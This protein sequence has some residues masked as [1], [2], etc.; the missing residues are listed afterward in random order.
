MYQHRQ[1]G[2][3]LVELMIA[4]SISLVIILGVTQVFV[5]SKRTY[6]LQNG[7]GSLQENGRFALDSLSHSIG[8]AGYTPSL[9]ALSAFNTA[10]SLDNTTANEDLSFSVDA[11]TASDTIEVNYTSATDCLGNA[12]TGVANDLF[13]LDGTNLM[14]LGSGNGTPGLMAEGVEN[15][16][17]L[18]GED[19]DADKVANRYVSVAN[20]VDWDS[21]VSVRVALLLETSD[22]VAQADA[23]KTYSLLNAP[24][25]G[26]FS[27][28]LLRREFTRTIF[29]RN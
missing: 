23:D 16:Q 9:T 26:P 14:C 21:V 5:A 15:M 13:F 17:I 19:T 1:Q 28:T 6:N 12:T 2:L 4:M 18:Y 3:S 29:L 24:P 10:T 7:I 8:L 22:G 25:L 27:D 20:I 11:G